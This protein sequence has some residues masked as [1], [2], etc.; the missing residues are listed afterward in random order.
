MS[1]GSRSLRFADAL[2]REPYVWPGGYPL[3]GLMDDGGAICKRCAAEEREWI[4]LTN[5][6]DG[7]CMVD[8]VINWEDHELRCDCCGRG[9]EAAYERED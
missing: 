4:G 5:G 7:W 9:I 2:V 8:T 1:T 3:Y 6:R